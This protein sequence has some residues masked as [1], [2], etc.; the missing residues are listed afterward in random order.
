M[1][2]ASD[3]PVVIVDVKNAKDQTFW[4]VHSSLSCKQDSI[5]RDDTADS[6]AE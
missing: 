2:V 1:F 6:D 3:Y 5:E 4:N